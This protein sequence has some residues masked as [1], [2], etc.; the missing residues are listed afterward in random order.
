[1][2]HTTR[3][4]NL[5]HTIIVKLKNRRALTKL[6]GAAQV[7]NLT[8]DLRDAI[9]SDAETRS[10]QVVNDPLGVVQPFRNPI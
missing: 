3:A 2:S 10:A 5:I 7:F 6:R 4:A 8:R 1:V 9:L